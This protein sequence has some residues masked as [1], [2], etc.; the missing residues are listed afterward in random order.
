MSARH[1]RAM[2]MAGLLQEAFRSFFYDPTSRDLLICFGLVAGFWVAARRYDVF[3]KVVAWTRMHEMR[4]IDELILVALAAALA[5][6]WFAYRRWRDTQVEIAKRV[7]AEMRLRKQNADL[8]R[9]NEELER[10]AFVASHDLQEPLRK[11][12]TFSEYLESDIQDELTEDSRYSLGVIRNAVGRMR[13]LISDLLSYSDVTHATMAIEPVDLTELLASIVDDLSVQID[14]ADAEVRVGP[15]PGVRCDRTQA[16]QLFQNLLSNALKYRD[17]GRKC[18]VRV[19]ARPAGD[20]GGWQIF[21]KDNGI[22]FEPQFSQRTLLPFQRLHA[23][24]KYEGTGIGLSICKRIAERHDWDLSAEGAL[25][26]G[27]TIVLTISE[28]RMAATAA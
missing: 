10:F 22:G 15:L 4:E 12:Q 8:A 16:M 25:G 14:E 6:A 21:V 19:D 27:A 2:R 18:V 3:E 17:P 9:L 28:P 20:R 13:L 5:F 1:R 7:N 11:I 23:R 24:S 26:Q